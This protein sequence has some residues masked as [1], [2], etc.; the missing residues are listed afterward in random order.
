M[1]M[2][3]DGKFLK[4]QTIKK[5]L[6]SKHFLNHTYWIT[7]CRITVVA[8]GTK[9]VSKNVKYSTSQKTGLAV[10]CYKVKEP[11]KDTERIMIITDENNT[12]ENP[13]VV[14]EIDRSK[15]TAKNKKSN[16]KKHGNSSTESEEPSEIELS[17]DDDSDDPSWGRKRKK[18]NEAKGKKKQ[19]K[20]Y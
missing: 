4:S 19:R 13:A 8:P 16:G 10:G 1:I 12:S 6:S 15:P 14:K 20:K 18:K 3:F 9:L 17:S 5:I 11:N 2:R 7:G